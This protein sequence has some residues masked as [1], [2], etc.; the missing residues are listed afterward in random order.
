MKIV[1]VLERPNGN[2]CIDSHTSGEFET[3]EAH[4]HGDKWQNPTNH[5]IHCRHEW[6]RI[7]TIYL[8]PYGDKK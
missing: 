6:K 7:C 3:I 5:R 8:A 1:Y 4:T 2:R